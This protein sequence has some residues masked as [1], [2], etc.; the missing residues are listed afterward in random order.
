MEELNCY[1]FHC[2]ATWKCYFRLFV[3]SHLIDVLLQ[4]LLALVH[5]SGYICALGIDQQRPHTP[6]QDYL[7]IYTK[8]LNIPTQMTQS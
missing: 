3:L 7:K 2:I 5:I 1:V 4:P 6:Q 8:K